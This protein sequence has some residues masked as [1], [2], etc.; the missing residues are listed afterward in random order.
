MP[1]H[2]T[3]DELSALSALFNDGRAQLLQYPV[4]TLAGTGPGAAPYL[5]PRADT[6]TWSPA[7]WSAAAHY[8]DRLLRNR[9]GH[10]TAELLAL[11]AHPA[12]TWSPEVAWLAKHLLLNAPAPLPPRRDHYDRM[13]T[14]FPGL[15]GLAA[16]T[17]A[18]TRLPLRLR[19]EPTGA[20]PYLASQGIWD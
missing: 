14:L 17:R 10:R 5:S 9:R 3:C 4:P 1:H 16:V 15:T 12:Q 19:D 20:H 7:G 11:A 13:L 6:H 2:D 8:L 18:E